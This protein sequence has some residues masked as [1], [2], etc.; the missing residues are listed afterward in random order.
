VTDLEKTFAL[1]AADL[2]ALNVPWAVIGGLAVSARAAPRFTQDVD[3]AVFAATDDEA[4]SIIYRMQVRGYAVGML[5]EQEEAGRL[6][7]VRLTR[8]VPGSAHL[9][10]DLLFASSGI[11]DLVVRQAERI[12][13]LPGCVAPVACVGHLI[14]LKLLSADERRL[15]DY[16]DL[17]ALAAV[18]EPGDLA[19]ART[20]V[21]AITARGFNR[22]RNLVQDLE[23]LVR[24][25]GL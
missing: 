22:G 23:R 16:L 24:E 25:H 9:F 1:A 13:I 17:R 11:E 2:D 3:F 7:T 5:V 15:Q 20:A 6:A 19:Q 8:P 18:A 21:D 10:I 12:E 4:E 14:A